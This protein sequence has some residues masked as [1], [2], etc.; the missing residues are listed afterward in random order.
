MAFSTNLRKKLPKALFLPG[1]LSPM[2]FEQILTDLKNRIYY[3]VYLFHGEE[4]YHIDLLSDFIGEKV[5]SETEKEFNQT[6]LYGKDADAAT[7]I[8]HARRYPMMANYQVLI[9]REAQE[10]QELDALIP[11]IQNPLSSTL[12]V[13]CYKHGKLDKRRSIVKAA[14][15]TGVV[16]D[17]PRIY[18][19]K[20]PAWIEEY[21][22]SRNYS[23]TAKAAI[24]LTEFLGADLS[25]IVNEIGKLMINIPA[26]ALIN[27]DLVEKHIGISKDYNVFELQKALGY[28]DILKANQIIRYFGANPRENPMMKVIPMLYSFFSKVLLYQHLPDRSRNNVASVLGIH[29]F[30]VPDYQMTA[31][32]YPVGK[33]MS[34]IGILREYDLKAKGVDSGSVPDR[35]LMKE[36]IFRILH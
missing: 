33:L 27:E 23:I 35:E 13:L 12:L 2:T 10:I 6:V 19:N 18:D 28:R 11:Y 7:I 8:S 9:I 32:N 3:P 29:P 21:I 16:F 24:M 31:R 30:F 14:D 4:S 1:C 15:K 17:S 25:R 20:V 34:V 36:M 5:L 22:R 26:G